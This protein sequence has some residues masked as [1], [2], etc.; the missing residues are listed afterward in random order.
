MLSRFQLAKLKL[1]VPRILLGSIFLISGLNG[2]FKFY[3]DPAYSEAGQTFI[4]NLKASGFWWTALKSIEVIGGCAL[5]SGAAGRFGVLVLAPVTLAIAL[6]HVFLSP[7]GS[8]LAI[9]AVALEVFLIIALRK[10][11]LRI[12]HVHPHHESHHLPPNAG[13]R[14]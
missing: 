7:Q 6:F 1:Q 13:L 14:A 8:T 9:V 2:F 12:V 3:S 4:D 11:L 10:N 5:I